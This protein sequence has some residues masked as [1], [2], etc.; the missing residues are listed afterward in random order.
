M[1]SAYDGGM[2]KEMNRPKYVEIAEQVT[3]IIQ[4]RQIKPH[5]PVPS[6]G[7]LAAQFGVSRMTANFALDLLAER[8]LVYR[9]KRRGTFLTEAPP[10][11]NS[12]GVTGKGAKRQQSGHPCRSIAFVVSNLDYYTTR[13][14]SALESAAREHQ[15]ELII[16]LSKDVSDEESSLIQL[17][18]DG[19]SG[20]LL[21]PRGRH[22]CSPTALKLQN[23]DIPS[24]SL[25]GCLRAYRWISWSMTIFKART[26]W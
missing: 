4:E 13:I 5:G 3:Q 25:I 6:E 23:R 22:Q 18:A 21:F 1:I 14:V 26:K 19:V 10:E 24:Y 7:E 8:G 12:E 15:F 16:K 2:K 11:R 9:L 17:A 20:I